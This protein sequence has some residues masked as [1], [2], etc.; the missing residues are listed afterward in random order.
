MKTEI[1]VKEKINDE[2]FRL[3]YKKIEDE[4]N[5]KFDN[6][7][8]KY[9]KHLFTNK[10]TE[11]EVLENKEYKTLLVIIGDGRGPN[12]WGS[13]FDEELYDCGSGEVKYKWFFNR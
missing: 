5:E 6:I 8:V 11:D 9:E 10:L 12:W 7:T 2:Y 13:V 1:L 4:L 3:N